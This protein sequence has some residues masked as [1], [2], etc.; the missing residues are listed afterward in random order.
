[1]PWKKQ[2][3]VFLQAYLKPNALLFSMR[4]R[5]PVYPWLSRKEE[6]RLPRLSPCN[7]KKSRIYLE[8]CTIK[9][10]RIYWLL[11]MKYG[12]R[13]HDHSRYPRMDLACQRTGE[14][15]KK[16]HWSNWLRNKNRRLS[17]KL[18]G[19]FN[20]RKVQLRLIRDQEKELRPTFRFFSAIVC[21][22]SSRVLAW[23]RGAFLSSPTNPQGL[24]LFI[25]PVIYVLSRVEPAGM[26]PFPSMSVL[27]LGNGN[28]CRALEWFPILELTHCPAQISQLMC[29]P[30]DTT[31]III[32]FYRF[33]KRCVLNN[34]L[35]IIG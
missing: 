22:P 17:H 21:I 3:K 25:P 2:Q 5:K 6:N 13:T 35:L 16:G 18:L 24:S 31:D 29:A 33:K 9:T 1:M 27:P 14:T 7:Q 19:N 8:V 30:F 26:V 15:V 12:N 28:R 32:C 23:V 20:S 34:N 11:L 4:Y 10:K